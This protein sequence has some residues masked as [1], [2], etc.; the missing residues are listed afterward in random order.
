MRHP[1]CLVAERTERKIKFNDFKPVVP[2]G[3]T[4]FLG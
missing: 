4:G 3:R 1:Q 2:L